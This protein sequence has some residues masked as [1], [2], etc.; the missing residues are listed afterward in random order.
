MPKPTPIR[1]KTDLQKL[2]T[3]QPNR[4]STAFDTKSPLEIARI[5]NAEDATVAKAI[6]ATLPQVAKAIDAVAKAIG[7][8]GRLIYVGAGSSGRIAALDSSE[9]PPTFN[10]DPQTVQYVMAGGAK[11]LGEAAEFNEDSREQGET[12]MARHRPTRNDVVIGI[13]ASGRTPYTI[14]AVEYA[15]SRGALTAAIV[16]VKHSELGEVVDIEIA[17]EVGPEVIS[18][19][20]RLKAG[21]AQKLCCN[22]ITTGAFTRLGYV[23]G[24]LMVNVH[25]K[26]QKLMERGISILQRA[27]GVD[28]EAAKRALQVAEN[29]VPVALVMIKRDCSVNEARARLVATR[30]HVRRAI[31]ENL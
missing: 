21:T 15:K 10:A 3:E 26:N 19:S 2:A 1:R 9:C 6:K 5:M 31:E 22:M 16:C 8:G 11:A 25:L 18:G 14:A 28:R 24:N 27:A 30:G 17:V 13:A 12:D 23:Y 29:R 20:T 7:N 4:S